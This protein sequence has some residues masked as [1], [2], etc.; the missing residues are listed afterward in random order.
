MLLH[1]LRTGRECSSDLPCSSV[2]SVLKLRIGAA[3]LSS[4]STGFAFSLLE[5]PPRNQSRL[6]PPSDTKA[7]RGCSGSSCLCWHMQVLLGFV[8][9]SLPLRCWCAYSGHLL[10]GAPTSSQALHHQLRGCRSLGGR[11]V[12]PEAR[13]HPPNCCLVDAHGPQVEPKPPRC[14]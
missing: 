3:S 12:S 9:Q 14:D 2:F 11:F 10:L 13:H 1:G 4:S 8:P 5:A 6:G 7:Q